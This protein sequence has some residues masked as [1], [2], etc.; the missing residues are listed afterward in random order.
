ML[1][2]RVVLFLL[3]AL[4]TSGLVSAARATDVSGNLTTQTWTKANS[5]YRVTSSITVPSGNTLTIEPGVDVLFDVSV[6]F[7]VWGSLNAVGTASDSIRFVPGAVVSWRGI[8]FS[9]GDTNTIAYARISRAIEQGTEPGKTGGGINISGTGTRLAIANSVVSGNTATYGGGVY[10]YGGSLTVTGCTITGNKALYGGGL[11]N[12]GGT[13]AITYTVIS[14][15]LSANSASGVFNGTGDMIIT[16]CTIAN[17]GPE[18]SQSGVIQTGS[19][20][21]I[22]NT[23]VWG[24]GSGQQ[25]R[26]S[27]SG[28]VTAT[29]SDIQFDWGAFPGVGNI[30]ADP[31]FVDAA[32]GDFRLR[33]SSPCIDA[34]DPASALDFDGSRADMGA[35]AFFVNRPPVWSPTADTTTIE[36]RAIQFTV[37]ASDPDGQA[38]TYS[39]SDLPPGATFD[40]SSRIFSWTPNGGWVVPPATQQETMV[41]FSVSDG[42]STA[43]DTVRITVF[44]PQ[45]TFTVFP[46]AP[47]PFNPSTTIRFTLPEAGHVTL[48]VYDVN[49]RLVRTLVGGPLAA[50]C[51]SV[52][53]DGK[54]AMGR[55]VASGVYVYR[56]TAPQGVVTK[57]MVLVR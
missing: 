38:L 42:L 52:V 49:G 31:M 51:H 35:F 39:A 4:A 26:G 25:I 3:L 40:P 44:P 21:I 5:P 47:N 15:Q 6:P 56:L 12:N 10:N 45:W 46:N 19:A 13:T 27:G 36:G 24:N 54:D 20:L 14:G 33:G 9:Q 18:S 23:I 50:G 16:N 53:W 17:N 30:T 57:R 48:A 29:Y 2:S 22:R 8:R 43:N 7:T 55:A 32:N 11:Y 1:R 34:G 41:V 28:S 37:S